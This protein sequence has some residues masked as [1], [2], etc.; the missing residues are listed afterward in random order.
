MVA[1]SSA[2][3]RM[4]PSS[5]RRSPVRRLCEESRAASALISASRRRGRLD[6]ARSARSFGQPEFSRADLE[7]FER[8]LPVA[9]E[10]FGHETI[11]ASPTPTR[12]SVHGE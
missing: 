4:E 5:R 9:V 1:I 7:E 6:G 11:G 2:S 3:R 10:R 8:E 12:A